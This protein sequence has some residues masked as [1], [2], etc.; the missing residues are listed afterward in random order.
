MAPSFQIKSLLRIWETKMRLLLK[1][2]RIQSLRNRMTNLYIVQSQKENEDLRKQ[3]R[4]LQSSRKSKTGAVRYLK[5]KRKK[6][7][8]VIDSSDSDC[9]DSSSSTS[10]V[11]ELSDGKSK[12]KR[13][14]TVISRSTNNV[15]TPTMKSGI[16]YSDWVHWVRVWQHSV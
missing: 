10:S 14:K 3:I 4:E 7:V 8:M 5:T 12:V 9:T 13:S 15:E 6:R 11:V 2:L 16:K 1:I